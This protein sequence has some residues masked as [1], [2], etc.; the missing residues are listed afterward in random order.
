MNRLNPV[1]NILFLRNK[2]ILIESD[3]HKRIDP[4]ILQQGSQ[5]LFRMSDP[6]SV[7][8]GPCLTAE[9]LMAVLAEVSPSAVGGDMAVPDDMAS[10][11]AGAFIWL[12]VEQ[13]P[14]SQEL[15]LPFLFPSIAESLGYAK[16]IRDFRDFRSRARRE[17]LNMCLARL[18]KSS[19]LA[20]LFYHS[21]PLST[22]NWYYPIWYFKTK[23]KPVERTSRDS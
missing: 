2:F 11:A 8:Q 4:R 9:G 21:F 12:D 16:T 15:L 5:I 6:S 17:S 3:V 1:S 13:R 18:R 22:L 23:K 19:C 20:G 10:M 14:Y 7:I